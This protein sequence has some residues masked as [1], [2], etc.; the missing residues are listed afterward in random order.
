MSL[1]RLRTA[2]DP[3]TE[4]H[5]IIYFNQ[6]EVQRILHVDPD[7]KPDKWQTCSDVVGINWK[8]SPRTVLD[9]YRDLIPTG[10]RIWI[11]RLLVHPLFGNTDGVLPVTSTRYSIDALKLP[12]VS[13]WRAWYDDGEVGGWTQE[14]AGLT[15][16]N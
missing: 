11:F 6:P 5:S 1:G 15:F 9:I 2:Y 8:D 3:C 7:H 10:L 12:T 16:V 13:P 4:K 14:Y